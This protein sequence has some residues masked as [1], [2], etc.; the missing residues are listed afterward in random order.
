M[1]MPMTQSRPGRAGRRAGR[2]AAT[3]RH[4]GRTGEGVT[5]QHRVVARCVQLAVDGVVEGGV[6]KDLAALEG[7]NFVEDKVSLE[8]RAWES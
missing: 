4:L 3:S 5:N 2:A 6:R 7:E 1:L 8:G